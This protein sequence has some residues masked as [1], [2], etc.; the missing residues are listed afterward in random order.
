MGSDSI[1][2]GYGQ[3]DVRVSS[4]LHNHSIGCV[5]FTRN[6]KLNIVGI[7]LRLVMEK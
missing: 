6:Q 3:M 4:N 2:V 7:S 1:N 5:F